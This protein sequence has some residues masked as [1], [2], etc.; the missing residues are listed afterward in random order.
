MSL[1]FVTSHYIFF[2][3]LYKDYPNKILGDIIN[4]I[5]IVYVSLVTDIPPNYLSSPTNSYPHRSCFYFQS[6]ALSVLCVM[7]PVQLSSV[8]NLCLAL[9]FIGQTVV[10]SEPNVNLNRIKLNWNLNVVFITLLTNF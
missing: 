5:I 9:P 2:P 1:Q 6:A 7:F 3:S 8:L 10:V 4:I